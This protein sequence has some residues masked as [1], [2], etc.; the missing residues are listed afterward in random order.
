M[1]NEN[2]LVRLN[3]GGDTDRRVRAVP[4]TEYSH[5]NGQCGRRLEDGASSKDE[6]ITE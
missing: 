1:A 4:S 5:R 6:G 2:T 3:V